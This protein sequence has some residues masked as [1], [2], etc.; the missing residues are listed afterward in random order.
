MSEAKDVF[1]SYAHADGAWVEVLAG[2]L[3]RAGL[4][5]WFDEWEITAGDVLVHK[6]DQGILRSRNGVLVV[7]PTSMSRPIVAEEYAAMWTRAVAGQRE[8][9]RQP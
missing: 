8:C 7:S 6:L 3:H 1:V 4:E 5:V 2:N 9:F